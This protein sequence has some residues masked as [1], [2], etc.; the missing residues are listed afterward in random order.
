MIPTE[1]DDIDKETAAS[2]GMLENIPARL[3]TIKLVLA[4]IN[5]CQGYE[6]WRR[7]L[8]V[9]L[10]ESIE[11]NCD[12]LIET[13]GK[14]RL[15]AVAWITR[16]L[17]ELLVWV[18]YCGVS[19]EN[20][21]R[22]HEDTLRDSKGLTEIL[23]VACNAIGIENKWQSQLAHQVKEVASEKLGLED[24]DS[25]FLACEQR[26]ESSGC[27]L[28][29]GRCVPSPLRLSIEICSSDRGLSARL[30]ASTRIL[31]GAAGCLYEARRVI[32]GT[33]HSCA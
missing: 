23:D 18:K 15:P 16:N 1:Y 4:D 30:H 3:N 33:E 22:F 14:D 31:P 20:A 26:V 7:T 28:G 2:H 29:H 8:T 6:P 24:I 32:H 9:H 25:N 10:V 5:K 17:L 19:R 11:H 27:R 12:Q 13:M 21:W